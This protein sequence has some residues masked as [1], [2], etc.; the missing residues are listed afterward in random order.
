MLHQFLCYSHRLYCLCGSTPLKRRSNN[1]THILAT[2]IYP[3]FLGMGARWLDRWT[4]SWYMVYVDLFGEGG[5]NE[6][7]NELGFC[8]NLP[9]PNRPIITKNLRFAPQ[10]SKFFGSFQKSRNSIVIWNFGLFSKNK[11]FN[12][13]LKFGPLFK[14]RWV[15]VGGCVR[16]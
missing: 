7:T 8:I 6:L 3:I 13:N 11:E 9:P 12:W 14:K 15:G 2:S 4:I 16:G 1:C 10:F 5:G